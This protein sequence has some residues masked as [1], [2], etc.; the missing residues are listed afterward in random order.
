MGKTA[1][2]LEF[3]QAAQERGFVT[4]RA[5][6][7]GELLEDLIGGIQQLGARFVKPRSKVAGASAGVLGSGV[8]LT[9]TA[10][11]DA[12]LSF[13]NKLALLSEAI[14]KRGH[15]TVLL[16]DEVQGATPAMRVLT[17]AYQHLVGEGQGLKQSRL[18]LVG[19]GVAGV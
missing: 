19:C 11:A 17:T 9:F 7:G 6:A 1:L 2:L 4:A 10:E 15:G 5:A 12:R 14:D 8:G 18:G 13:L 16:V 3:A